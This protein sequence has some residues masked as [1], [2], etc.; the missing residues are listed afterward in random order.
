[1]MKLLFIAGSLSAVAAQDDVDVDAIVSAAQQAVAAEY[2]PIV[3]AAKA[4]LDACETKLANFKCP[5]VESSS[6]GAGFSWS[7]FKAVLGQTYNLQK[8]LVSSAYGAVIKPHHEELVYASVAKAQVAASDG[9][10]LIKAKGFDLY[11]EHLSK[12][13]EK[14]AAKHVEKAH[15]MVADHI[16]NLQNL[17]TLHAHDKIELVKE[18]VAS[19]STL[20][21]SKVTEGL[22]AAQTK[23]DE[24][25]APKVDK[26]VS[27]LPAGHGV[28]DGLHD[29]LFFGALFFLFT[30]LALFVT[31]KVAGKVLCVSWCI[32]KTVFGIVWYF[33]FLPLRIMTCQVCKKRAPSPQTFSKPPP[34]A[35]G[36]GSNKKRK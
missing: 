13:Y 10:I 20:A 34:K 1:M 11:D 26:V 29:R 19:G 27:L 33:A 3:N 14:H 18:Q 5:V 25:L 35:N 7:G 31:T 15:G 16:E 4:E 12:H 24:F 9:L 8:S 23:F 36:N 28:P 22:T 32:F 17:Y 30:F 21:Y 6:G 2:E